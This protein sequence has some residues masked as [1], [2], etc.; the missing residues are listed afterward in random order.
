MRIAS[1]VRK[2]LRSSFNAPI[3]WIVLVLFLAWSSVWFFL[4]HDFF[5]A[6]VASL[7]GY[8]GVMPL[9]FVVLVPA[10]TMRM[11]AEEESSGTSEVLRTL[12]FHEYE[13]VLGKY[14]AGLLLVLLAIALTL[15]VPWLVTPLG[16]FERGEI[17]GQYL[18]LVLL[19][20]AALAIGQFFSSLSRNQISAFLFSALALLVLVL[21]AR[22]N[23]VVELPSWLAAIVDYLSIEYHFRSFNRGVL[24]TRDLVYFLGVTALGLRLTTFVLT[25]RKYR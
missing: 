24:D 15:F 18:G 20:S 23:S 22:V 1:I 19:A 2:E 8:F 13:L 5:A 17:L 7:R 3:A 25:A 16:D 4:I 11:W 6:N 14:L 12:P 21:I 9:V 10:I